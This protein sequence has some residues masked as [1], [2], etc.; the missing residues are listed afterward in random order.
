MINQFYTVLYNRLETP[1]SG[2]YNPLVDDLLVIPDQ[3]RA[4]YKV[5]ANTAEKADK[6]AAAGV[7]T[8]LASTYRREIHTFDPRVTF[9]P[10]DIQITPVNLFDFH[11]QLLG[12]PAS[13]INV[14]VAGRS[15][16]KQSVFRSPQTQE[17]AAALLVGL[18]EKVSQAND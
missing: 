11:A 1:P 13:L 3:L 6:W 5:F 14:A 17:K 18:V 9:D 12:L 15:D 2:I 10:R 7:K 8:V 16:L 4:Y